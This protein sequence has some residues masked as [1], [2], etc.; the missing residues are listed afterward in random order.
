MS[1]DQPDDTWREAGAAGAWG[2]EG[3]QFYGSFWLAQGLE[4]SH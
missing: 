2:G 3:E 1:P 4:A